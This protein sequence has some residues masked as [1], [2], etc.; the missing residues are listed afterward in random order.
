MKLL[1]ETMLEEFR[2]NK[3]EALIG[4][5]VRRTDYKDLLGKN[6]ILIF[7]C[8]AQLNTC[9]CALSVCLSVSNRHFSLFG[10]PM[11]TYDSLWQLMTA[12][13]SLWQL[14]TTVDN[15][16]QFLTAYDN[17]WQLLTTF[18]NL[19][20]LMTTYTCTLCK[21]SSSQDLVVGLV[22]LEQIENLL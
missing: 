12:H 3:S 13:D 21:L 16:W 18:D 5:H 4:V 14:L 2:R 7:S 8:E 20:Q 9:T 22:F 10:Q 15:C 6:T 19:W 17:F 1:A 11:T